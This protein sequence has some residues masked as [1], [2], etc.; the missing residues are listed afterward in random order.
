MYKLIKPLGPDACFE[1]LDPILW[2]SIC[3]HFLAL[4]PTFPPRRLH[5]LT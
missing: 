2:V 4:T 5:D 3:S 1:L